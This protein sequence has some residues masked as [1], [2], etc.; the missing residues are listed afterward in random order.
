MLAGLLG[1][2]EDIADRTKLD[3]GIAALHARKFTVARYF[4]EGLSRTAKSPKVKAGAFNGIGIMQLLGGNYQDS[5][6]SFKKA[7]SLYSG[8]HPSALN[9]GMLQAKFGDFANAKRTLSGVPNT[10]LVESV[11]LVIERHL[12]NSSYAAS[13]CNKL[14]SA[15]PSH[16]PT[17]VNCALLELEENKNFRKARRLLQDAVKIQGGGEQWDD[18][19]YKLLED[20]DNAEFNKQLQA[21]K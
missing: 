7:L 16:K 4:L 6:L 20:I 3:L 10:W 13:L 21:N 9:L 12:G 18:T 1:T 17:K 15:K 19:I 14:L 5:T 2:G 8:Y 11:R